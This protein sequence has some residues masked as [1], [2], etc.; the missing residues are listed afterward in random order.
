MRNS[1]AQNNKNLVELR[2]EMA[3]SFDE[4]TAML[5]KLENNSQGLGDGGRWDRD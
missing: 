1:F 5:D 3:N 2:P 4:G